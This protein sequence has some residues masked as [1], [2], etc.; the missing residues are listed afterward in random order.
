M[1]TLKVDGIRSNSASSD[2]ITLASDGTCTANITNNLS[3]RNLIIN[4]AMQVA[5]RGT[6]FASANAYTLDRW[7]YYNSGLSAAVTV[8]QEAVTDLVGFTKALKI[9]TTTAATG[10]LASWTSAKTLVLDVKE[11]GGDNE[12]QV[13]WLNNCGTGYTG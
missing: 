10:R 5:Q 13:H 6:S 12:S 2:A 8:S 11:H 7:R 3:N 1:S 4:G 9:N